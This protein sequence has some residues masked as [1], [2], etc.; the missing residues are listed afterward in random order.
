MMFSPLLVVSDDVVVEA[1][2]TRV[3]GTWE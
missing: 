1:V 3:G 2:L